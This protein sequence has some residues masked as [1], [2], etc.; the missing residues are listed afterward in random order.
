[1]F[2]IRPLYA[3]VDVTFKRGKAL[4]G[5]NSYSTSSA[6]MKME[7]TRFTYKGSRCE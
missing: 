6:T 1:M 5:S 7:M 3:I 2:S 4:M